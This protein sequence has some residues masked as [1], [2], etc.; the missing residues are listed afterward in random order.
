MEPLLE[1]LTTMVQLS[2]YLRIK[3]LSNFLK[4]QYKRTALIKHCLEKLEAY[5]KILLLYRVSGKKVAQK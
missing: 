5:L 1:L 2:G 4:V 3:R